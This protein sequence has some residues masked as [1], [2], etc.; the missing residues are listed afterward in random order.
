MHCILKKTVLESAGLLDSAVT[1]VWSLTAL[2]NHQM[3]LALSFCWDPSLTG[4]FFLI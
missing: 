4:R 3:N 1:L 2:Y